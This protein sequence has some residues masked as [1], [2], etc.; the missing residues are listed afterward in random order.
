MVII[1]L[2]IDVYTVTSS[3]TMC[4]FRKTAPLRARVDPSSKV[5][6]GAAAKGERKKRAPKKLAIDFMTEAIDAKKC[7][8]PPPK[9]KGSS[10][11]LSDKCLYGDEES[12]Y[13]PQVCD[14][15]P[16][17]IYTR[18]CMNMYS[19]YYDIC[20]ICISRCRI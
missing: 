19:Y 16:A 7:F 5:A 9:G 4:V 6:S 8:A 12:F 20:R 17:C 2:D 14:L 10:I 15:I 13:Q 3:L 18:P 11:K 1:F